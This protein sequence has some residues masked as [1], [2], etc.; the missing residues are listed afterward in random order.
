M[1]KLFNSNMAIQALLII[2]ALVLLWLRALIAPP[3]MV[4]SPTDGGLYTLLLNLLSS[5]PRAAV[6]IAMILVLVEGVLL[7]LLL[8]DINLVPQTS[9]LPTL[10]Y[11]I[12]MSAP[13]TTLTPMILVAGVLIACI[14]Q[15]ALHGTLLTIPTTRICSATALI[16]LCSMFYLPALALLVSYILVAVSY[17]LYS[18]RDIATMILGFL[19]SYIFLLTVLYMTD[20]LAIWWSATAAALGDITFTTIATDTLPFIANIVLTLIFAASVFMLWSKLGE[21][22]VMWQ[23]NA[24]TVMFF[25][26]GG[27]TMLFF[28]HML[29]VDLSFFAIPFALCGTHMLMPANGRSSASRRRNQ[30][31]WINDLLLVLIIIAAFV[32]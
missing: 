18:W 24:S 8:A 21:H 28:S 19:A 12:F 7:N 13:A 31:L 20:N 29:P 9:L 1:L 32:C 25:T 2:V 15:L 27:I 26:V 10:L 6:V 4:A 30:R 23:K 5:A 11:V 22:P 17:R 14:H 16:S 3:P